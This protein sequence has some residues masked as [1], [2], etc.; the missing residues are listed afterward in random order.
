MVENNALCDVEKA[1]KEYCTDNRIKYTEESIN[2]W[3]QK[4]I[5]ISYS[6]G[7]QPDDTMIRRMIP[8]LM[9]EILKIQS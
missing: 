1:L 9:G 3:A 7:G 2:R 6:I 5:A 8:V 4:L